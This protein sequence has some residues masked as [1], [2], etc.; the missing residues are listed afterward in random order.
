MR[1]FNLNVTNEGTCVA[2]Y[3]QLA[4]YVD[5]DSQ[6]ISTWNIDNDI[7][8]NYGGSIASGTSFLG[9]RVC[10]VLCSVPSLQLICL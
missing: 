9:K 3:V 1:V 2:N 6:I 5:A 7:L 10:M 8:A 4:F